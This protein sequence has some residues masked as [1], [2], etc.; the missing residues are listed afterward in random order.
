MLRS[1]C[2]RIDVLRGTF[3]KQLQLYSISRTCK[4]ISQVTD[5][6]TQGRNV[7]NVVNT[8]VRTGAKLYLAVYSRYAHVRSLLALL[9]SSQHSQ[10]QQ[11]Q[12]KVEKRTGRYRDISRVIRHDAFLNFAPTYKWIA[13]VAFKLFL[14]TRE[15]CKLWEGGG[16]NARDEN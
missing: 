1:S 9:A 4:S 5:S 11:Q 6:V 8:Y 13:V 14:R 16:S 7:E 2:T 3:S 15:L 12:Q 10:Q